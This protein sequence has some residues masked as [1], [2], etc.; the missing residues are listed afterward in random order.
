MK[1]KLNKGLVTSISTAS[2]AFLGFL[3]IMILVLCGYNFKIDKFNVFVANNRTSFLTGFMK[4]FTHLGSFY[5][6]A[7]LALIGVV[8]IW[9]V[10]KDKR[11]SAFYAG[12][13]ALVCISN[14][15]IKQIVRRI[16]PE[17]LMIIEENTEGATLATVWFM[18][19]LKNVCETESF[20]LTENYVDA[21]IDGIEGN[22]STRE[23]FVR[24]K[25][26]Y[27]KETSTVYSDVYCVTGGVSMYLSFE[28]VYNFET[29]TMSQFVTKG[30][31]GT[32]EYLI[33]KNSNLYLLNSA[34]DAYASISAEIIAKVTELSGTEF[35]ADLPDYSD[36]YN[37]A[38]PYLN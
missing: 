35:G 15:I 20:V 38:N 26:S 21:K 7:V 27:D 13:F 29:S 28:V 16:R 17:H 37:N 4:I 25:M 18:G 24:F 9:F 12:C 36:Q 10:K 2:V 32:V 5:T 19:F 11:M 34:S 14:F 23:Y 6:L 31:M 22:G 1:K 33:Y 30:M 3:A 8:L